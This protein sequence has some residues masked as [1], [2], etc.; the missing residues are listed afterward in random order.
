MHRTPCRL[1]WQ[2]AQKEEQRLPCPEASKG[3]MALGRGHSNRKH[4][5]VHDSGSWKGTDW[6]VGYVRYGHRC[7]WEERAFKTFKGKVGSLGGTC[8]ALGKT[9]KSSCSAVRRSQA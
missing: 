3:T 6:A 2:C 4:T 8:H 7:V 1:V 5:V 9:W